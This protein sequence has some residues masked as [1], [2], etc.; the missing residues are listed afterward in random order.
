M[1]DYAGASSAIIDAVEKKAKDLQGDSWAAAVAAPLLL[2]LAQ[3]LAAVREG[4]RR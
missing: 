3:A 1:A 4:G 2:Q